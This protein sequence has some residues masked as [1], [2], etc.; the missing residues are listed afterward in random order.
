MRASRPKATSLRAQWW[1]LE[2]SLHGQQTPGGYP[3]RRSVTYSLHRGAELDLLEAARFYRRAG[4]AKLVSI[5]IQSMAN[6]GPDARKQ[7]F[8]L[9][10]KTAFRPTVKVRIISARE[11]TRRERQQ[12]E[13]A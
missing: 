12:Y 11:A 7:R 1:A 13:C 2:L 8:P 4:G 5:A 9:I 3:G 10:E 6:L